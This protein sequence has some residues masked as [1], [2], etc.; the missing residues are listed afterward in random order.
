MYPK[1]KSNAVFIQGYEL[2]KESKI[3]LKKVELSAI[4]APKKYFSGPENINFS[5]RK[6]QKWR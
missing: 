2:K 6:I 4:L 1:M 3:A 5:T